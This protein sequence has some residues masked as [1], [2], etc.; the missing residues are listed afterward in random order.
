MAWKTLKDRDREALDALHRAAGAV[1][2]ELAGYV[3]AH[4]EGR[5]ILYGSVVR[6]TAVPGSDLDILVDYP[7]DADRDAWIF[8][9][10]ACRRHGVR[11]D[12]MPTAWTKPGFIARVMERG[13]DIVTG[14]ADLSGEIARFRDAIDPP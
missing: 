12:I 9:E 2:A 6:S 14:A 5:F 10:D 1:R 8:A 4:P 13:A 7:S 3:G 11:G